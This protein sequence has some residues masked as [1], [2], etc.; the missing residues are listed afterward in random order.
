MSER[1]AAPYWED[2]DLLFAT[3]W[4]A[5]IDSRRDWAEFK[6][7]IAAAGLRAARLHDL[8]HSAATLMLEADTDLQ[9]AGQILGHGSITQTSQYTHILADRKRAAAARI[10]TL[11][12]GDRAASS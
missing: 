6:Q 2:N 5:P 4:G 8:R 11:V 10:E 3:E 1:L 12:W 7:V 9:T